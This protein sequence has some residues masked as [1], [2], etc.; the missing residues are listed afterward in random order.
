MAERDE[1]E[2]QA[3][4]SAEFMA[5][6]KSGEIQAE[7]NFKL[8]LGL[9]IVVLLCVAGVANSYMRWGNW[10]RDHGITIP[11]WLQLGSP[12]ETEFKAR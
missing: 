6:V 4:D 1:M 2:E 5:K 3:E 8:H 10:L 7:K 9:V 12:H 11:H